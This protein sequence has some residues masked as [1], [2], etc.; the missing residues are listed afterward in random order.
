MTTEEFSAKIEAIAKKGPRASKF[1]RNLVAIAVLSATIAQR[2]MEIESNKKFEIYTGKDPLDINIIAKDGSRY[3]YENPLKDV[4]KQLEDFEKAYCRYGALFLYGLGNGVLLK[5]ILQN[6]THKTIVVFEPEIE[7]MYIVFHFFDFSTEILKNRLVIFQT[8]VMSFAHYYTILKLKNVLLSARLYN[9]YLTSDFYAGY[10]DDMR[11][12][13]ENFKK[14]FMQR[15]REVGNDGTDA[16]IG[17]NHTTAHIP[18]MINSIPLKHI[19][20]ERNKKVKTAIVVSTGPS[21][22]KQLELLKK[23]QN[24]ATIISADSSYPILK[25]HGIKPD[26]VTTIE[27]VPITSKFFASEVSEFDKDIIF[28][29]ATLTHP[30]TVTNLKDRNASYVFRPINYETGFNDNDFGYL[31]GGQSTSHLALDLA[32]YLGHEKVILVGQDLAYGEGRSSHAQGHIFSGAS[33][34]K[35]A[36]EYT[37]AYGGNGIVETMSVWNTFRQYFESMIAGFKDKTKLVYNCTEGGARIDGTIEIPFKTILEREVFSEKKPKL[38]LPK[39]LNERQKAAK[40]K[41]YSSHIKSVLRYGKSLQNKCEKLFLKLAKQV[42]RAKK[43]KEQGKENK[44]NYEKLQKLSF[45]IDTFKQMIDDKRFMSS[46][47]AVTCGF[48]Q[49]QELEFAAIIARPSDTM[50]EKKEKLLEWVSVQGNW[51]FHIAGAIS[52]M[53]ENIEKSSASWLR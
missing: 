46:Y 50:E 41:K 25:A 26:Y 43:L 3:M 36:S 51:L 30:D 44:I 5:G 35:K 7:I 39:K 47:Y 38:P 9:L 1:E 13:T 34:K 23:A 6:E 4:E 19:Q 20:N 52:V 53:R 14:A 24:H 28:M 29:A 42:E 21:L 49:N 48:I 22:S 40:L 11:N 18:A 31:G 27:R 33:D 8:E 2:L 15:M 16:L 10:L 45:E 12:I 17:V 32:L 37:I